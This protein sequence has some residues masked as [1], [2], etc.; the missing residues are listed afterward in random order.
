M[1]A[2]VPEADQEQAGEQA[3]DQY[4]VGSVGR[5]DGHEHHGHRTSGPADLHPASAEDSRDG[6]GDDRGDQARAGAH[7]GA[8]AEAESERQRNEADHHPCEEVASRACVIP[9][10]EPR[11]QCRSPLPR[12]GE[13][14]RE[15]VRLGRGGTCHRGRLAGG[16]ASSASSCTWTSPTRMLRA[17]SRRSRTSGTLTE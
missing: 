9:I 3:H 11:Q 13:P 1:G 7:A 17:A 5:D 2:D 14:G 12:C 10:A 16:K 6:T 15:G 8:D 4:P